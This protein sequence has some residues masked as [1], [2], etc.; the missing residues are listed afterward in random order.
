MIV[1]QDAFADMG[2]RYEAK[3]S[4]VGR[5]SRPSI[6]DNSVQLWPPR[7]LE[8]EIVTEGSNAQATMANVN[9][10]GPSQRRPSATT[11]RDKPFTMSGIQL[12][13]S[14]TFSPITWDGLVPNET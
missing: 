8:G 10:R 3:A 12:I 9:L 7:R 6:V 1:V 5:T 14:P 11:Q 4:F 13:P 2:C